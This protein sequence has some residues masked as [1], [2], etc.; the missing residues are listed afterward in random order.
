MGRAASMLLRLS[1]S[2]GRRS[3]LVDDNYLDRA[4]CLI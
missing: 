3:E 1:L 2:H 4:Y